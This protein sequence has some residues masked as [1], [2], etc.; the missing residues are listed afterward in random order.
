MIGA[1]HYG[2]LSPPART[3]VADIPSC[4]PSLS[5]SVY[6]IDVRVCM[7]GTGGPQVSLEVE[8]NNAA[9]LRLYSNLGFFRT[10]LLAKYYLNGSDAYRMRLVFK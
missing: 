7:C 4:L 1:G 10:K 5:P 2:K 3:R 8:Y 9:A 6:T